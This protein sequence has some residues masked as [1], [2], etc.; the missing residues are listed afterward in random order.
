MA[1]VSNMAEM[2]ADKRIVLRAV[3]NC[4][5]VLKDADVKLKADREVVMAAVIGWPAALQDAHGCSLQMS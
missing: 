5:W 1:A 4:G 2:R 3:S